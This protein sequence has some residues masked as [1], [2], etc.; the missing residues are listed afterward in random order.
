MWET[1]PWSKSKCPTSYDPREAD[2]PEMEKAHA[3]ETISRSD[4]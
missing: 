3:M 2:E 4:V 1:V